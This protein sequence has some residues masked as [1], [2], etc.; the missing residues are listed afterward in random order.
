MQVLVTG[1]A[2]YIG[3]HTCVELITKGYNIT[4]VDNLCNSSIKVI[5]RIKRLVNKDFNFYKID[6]RDKQKLIKV[7]S[8]HHI[9][10]VINFAGLKSTF[11]SIK[12]P[13]KYYNNNIIGAIILSEVMQQ[14]NCKIFIFSSS[15]TVYSPTNEM[16][17]KENYPLMATTPYGNSK[18]I[19]E[20]IFTDIFAI[21][22]NWHIALLRY[23]N[24]IGAH[25]SGIIGEE[26]H[27]IPNNLVPCIS[28]VAIGKL[29]K[30]KVFGNDYN[31]AD[32]TCI[33]DYIH[34]VDLAKG[35]I[36]ALISLANKPQIITVN[37]GTG[38]GY[39]VLE[40]INT[41]AKASGR[42]INY[43]IVE[44][45]KGDMPICYADVSLAYKEFGWKTKFGLEEMCQDCWRWQTR[46]S[47]QL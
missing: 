7:F 27:G 12:N 16:P 22:N 14:F 39:S 6:I 24:P 36:K 40:V 9:D 32:G 46:K 21:N 45:R 43:E 11:E 47:K 17:I 5:K 20:R 34:V 41:F 33:R 1:G 26:P 2:G 37:L 28:Q 42:Q 10:A 44:R 4:V 23:F 3:S 18:L 29:K 19:I 8:K 13:I 31:T 30:L 25:P 35:H 38:S 15:A